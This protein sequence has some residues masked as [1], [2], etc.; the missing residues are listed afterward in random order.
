MLIYI[1]KTLKIDFISCK[2]IKENRYK[3]FEFTLP[4]KSKVLLPPK[5]ILFTLNSRHTQIQFDMV[6][7]CQNLLHPII[8]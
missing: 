7:L 8:Y 5:D 3:F 6:S 1:K 2:L 4:D